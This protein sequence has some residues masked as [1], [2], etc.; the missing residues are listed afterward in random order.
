MPKEFRVAVIGRTGRGNYGHAMDTDWLTVPNVRL[1]AVAD[2]DRMGLAAAGKRLGVDQ[3]FADYRQMLD[4]VKPDVVAIG[5][6][7]VDMHHEMVLA[8][9]ERGIHIFMEKPMA[10]TLA[11]ADEMVTAC[12]RSHVKLAMALPTRYSPTV[13]T[14][15]RLIGEGAIG[16]VLEYRARG[17]EDHRGG[18][19]D[20]WVLGTHMMNLIGAFAGQPK[21]CFA[22]V[23]Q[24]GR[25]VT[26]ADVVEGNEGLGPLAGDGL[27]A[28]YG[29]PDGSTAY[30]ASYRNQAGKPPRYGLQIYGSRGA[31]EILEGTLPETWYLG[32]SSWSPGRSGSEWQ[33]VS[34]GGIGV[35]EPLSGTRYTTRQR[36]AIDDL[37]ESIVEDRQPL[38]SVYEARA[39]TEMVVAVFESHRQGGPVEMPLENRANPLTMLK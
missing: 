25:P 11:E 14:V 24:E 33:R 7:W 34:S 10:R 32:D 20:L 3:T 29:M 23:T 4:R 8:A 2:D 22:E 37:L 26:K 16:R 31:F 18:G 21:W 38:A 6:R 30:F 27:R 1:V 12:E 19:E 36:L 35:E 28:M 13:A 9:A 5:P 39:A 17:K 15:A